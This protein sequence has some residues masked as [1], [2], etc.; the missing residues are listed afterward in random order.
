MCSQILARVTSLPRDRTSSSSTAYSRDVTSMS[1]PSRYTRLAAVSM[2]AAPAPPAGEGLGELAAA[3]Q[4]P[5][6]PPVFDGA[7]RRQ[8][9]PG[10]PH[11]TLAG[12]L[13]ERP[14]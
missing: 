12:G 1:A 3:P 7:P 11:A 2:G 14:A 13:D 10:R 4:I 8:H 9:H 6:A 5:P